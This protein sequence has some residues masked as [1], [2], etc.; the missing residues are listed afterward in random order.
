MIKPEL[1]DGRPIVLV[2][3]G[4][5]GSGKTTLVEGLVEKFSG[6]IQRVITTTTRA[7]RQGEVDGVDYHFLSQEV[8]KTKVAEGAFYEWAEVHSNAYGTLKSSVN[9]QL[10][11]GFHL[12]LNIDVQGAASF[13]QV[14][15]Q[16]PLFL[17]RLVTVFI[18]PASV[19]Q[20]RE[21]L[22]LRA[23]DAEATVEKRLNLHYE[24]KET[25]EVTIFAL[26]VPLLNTAAKVVSSE[27]SIKFAG[28]SSS[29]VNVKE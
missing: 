15:Q 26:S 19:T 8:F 11:T 6:Q 10:E 14:V 21:R 4:P 5:A 9:S 2:I 3:S 23:L 1:R 22:R 16:D 7:P 29:A 20:L 25:Y 27:Q 17:G 18:M 13:R 28:S 12:I 24:R